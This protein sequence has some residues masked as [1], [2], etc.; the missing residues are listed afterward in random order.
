MEQLFYFLLLV[1]AVAYAFLTHR[2]VCE[3][4]QQLAAD[5]CYKREIQLL[6]KTAQYQKLR[7]LRW[8]LYWVFCFEYSSDISKRGSGWII[9]SKTRIYDIG[10]D[11]DAIL[12]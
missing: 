1:T 2:Q 12:Q 7:C 6:D 8:R 5:Y 4:A 9:L 10:I 11:E 3:R